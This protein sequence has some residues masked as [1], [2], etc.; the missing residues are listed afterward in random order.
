MLSR[1]PSES[2]MLKWYAADRIVYTGTRQL[3]IHDTGIYMAYCML[4]TGGNVSPDGCHT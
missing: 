1:S 4:E 3:Y 2:N